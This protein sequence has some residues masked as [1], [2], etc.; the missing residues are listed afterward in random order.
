MKKF[1]EYFSIIYILGVFLIPICIVQDLIKK[2]IENNLIYEEKY[3]HNAIF[4]GYDE[5]KNI[6]YAGCRS[7]NEKTFKADATGS[8]KTYSFCKFLW[9]LH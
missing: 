4:V 2:C 6:R 1:E 8:D 9:E 3:Y 5:Q 7:T